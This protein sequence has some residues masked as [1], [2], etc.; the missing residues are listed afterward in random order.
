[1]RKDTLCWNQNLVR[2]AS[3]LAHA[4][5][6]LLSNDYFAVRMSTKTIDNIKLLLSW[7]GPR[8]EE[9]MELSWVSTK[10]PMNSNSPS[11]P[12]AKECMSHSLM[13][14]HHFWCL[15]LICHW[16]KIE[17]MKWWC[18]QLLFI[19]FHCTSPRIS[20]K[21]FISYFMNI[22]QIKFEIGTYVSLQSSN[23]FSYCMN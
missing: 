6:T 3:M 9:T 19:L 5:S 16:L 23:D 14:S 22:L 13:L 4:L 2:V 15:R 8:K 21:F 7:K 12:D 18:H 1:M 11:N 10:K 17:K 20:W